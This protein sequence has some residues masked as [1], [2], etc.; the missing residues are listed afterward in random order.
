MDS[1]KRW[2]AVYTKS[3]AE[4]K[5]NELLAGKG[6]EVY[7]PLQKTVKQWSDRK[8][9][10]EE[11]LF[12]SYIFV[13]IDYKDHVNVLKTTGIVCFVKFAGNAEP[14]PDSQIEAVKA[15]LS[16]NIAFEVTNE[17]LKIGD[18]VE[19][20]MGPLK[21]LQ[22]EL[23]EYRGKRKVIIRIDAIGQNLIIDIPAAFIKVKN[24]S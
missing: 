15:L 6:V 24:P 13:R 23:T 5:V 17:N 18:Q 1:K 16:G 12:R 3:R 10:V 9:R 4:K 20:V 14:V 2:Y 19:I 11:P 21:G 22:G 7:L 8:K